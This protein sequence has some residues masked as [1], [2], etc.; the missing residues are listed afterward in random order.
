M[1]AFIGNPPY[2]RHH[3]IS[4]DW[5]TWYASKFAGFGIKASALAGLRRERY[6]RG[7]GP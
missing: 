1:T 6:H 3:D 7:P 2:V 4:E 5:K